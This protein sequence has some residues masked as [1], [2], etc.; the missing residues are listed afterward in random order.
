MPEAAVWLRAGGGGELEQTQSEA[1][2]VNRKQKGGYSGG[3]A[4][5]RAEGVGDKAAI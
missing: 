3:R 1:R 2:G 5:G 4:G